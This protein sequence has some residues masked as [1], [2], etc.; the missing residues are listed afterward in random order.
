M[1][2][3]LTGSV[4]L[5][6]VTDF[7]LDATVIIGILVVLAAVVNAGVLLFTYARGLQ[8]AEGLTVHEA[9]LKA[10]QLRLRPLVM[11]STAILFGLIPLA[12]HST[13]GGTCSSPWPLPPLVAC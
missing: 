4:G 10:A 12:R 13:Q 2:F 5:L 8:D 3:C 11:V 6:L 1:P 7:P 9:I